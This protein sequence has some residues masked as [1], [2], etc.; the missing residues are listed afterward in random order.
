M[1]RLQQHKHA[2]GSEAYVT[3]IGPDEQLLVSIFDAIWQELSL[4]EHTFSRFLPDSELTY[5]N[6]RA[7]LPTEVSP[8]FLALAKL[9]RDFSERTSGL[10][11]PFVL[12]AL[13][14]AGYGGSWPS[15]AEQGEAPDFSARV[16]EEK[17]KLQISANTITIP[18][19]TALDFGGIGKGYALDLLAQI[20]RKQNIKNYWLSLGG[21]VLAAGI[22][23]DGSPWNIA[24]GRV[25]DQDD[26]A[27]TFRV[28]PEQYAVATSGTVKR[29]G[30]DWN[31]LIDPRTGRSTESDILS[32]TVA[33]DSGVIA[34][35]YAK[36]LILVGAKEAPSLA[37]K[38]DISHYVLQVQTKQGTVEVTK[39]GDFT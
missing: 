16:F 34:D 8:E 5:L 17:S 7:G 30:K 19:R 37:K 13:Q 14:K 33:S 32:A 15:V 35:V 22:D 2:L 39:R 9:A 18:D 1:I 24:V 11:N 23:L 38:L 26:L 28:G 29:S 6:G 25:L 12:P 36:C 31:H 27:A 21:D 3:L 4:F 10:Y 20:L